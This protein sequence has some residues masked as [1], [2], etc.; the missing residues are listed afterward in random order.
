[1]I[2]NFSKKSL[3][4]FRLQPKTIQLCR[5]MPE[6]NPA[7]MSS[8]YEEMEAKPKDVGFSYIF[9]K[10]SASCHFRSLKQEIIYQLTFLCFRQ[11][12]SSCKKSHTSFT[13]HIS[14]FSISVI[15]LFFVWFK[16]NY[17]QSFSFW[18]ED[19]KNASLSFSLAITVSALWPF[20]IFNNF[21][22]F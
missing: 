8:F 6:M 2:H 17:R 18:E 7:K 15:L 9:Y 10:N 16:W 3:N 22:I 21:V 11:N 20:E 19:I 13:C 5:P 14:W 12:S 1:M 4:L